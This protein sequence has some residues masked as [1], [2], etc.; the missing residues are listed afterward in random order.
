MT[1][2][3]RGTLFHITHM[4]NLA[5]IAKRG[6]QCDSEMESAERSFRDVGNRGIKSQRRTCRVPIGPGGVVADYVPFY[7]AARS[8]MLFAIH[9]GNVPTYQK[10]QG[11]L[12][13]LLTSVG[14]ITEH[15]LRF[16]FTDR[17]AALGHARYGDDPTDLDS[18]VDW[19]LME[20]PMW[21]NTETEPDRRE[22]RMAELL[23]HGHV[24][25]TAITSVVTKTEKRSRQASAALATVGDATP[26]RVQ[27][28]WY[29]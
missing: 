29:F 25:W 23:V 11:K 15:G 14:L 24:P 26:V 4:S 13:Y 7:F 18:L 21:R 19:E 8:P 1:T 2:P 16:V 5:S 9:M 6:L 12:V 3:E 28:D 20:A 10:G 17:N 27:R 22:R